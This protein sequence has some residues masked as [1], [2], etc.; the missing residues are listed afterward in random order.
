MIGV[1]VHD[2]THRTAVANL[3]MDEVRF[4]KPVFVGD[5]LRIETEVDGAAP[6][7]LPA[8]RRHRHVH[9]PRLQ[10]ARRG[11]GQLQASRAAAEAGHASAGMI[12]R[13]WLFVPGDSE[14]K[15]ARALDAGADAVI[16]DLEDAVV[17]ERKPL[18]RQMTAAFLAAHAGSSGPPLWVRVNPLVLRADARRPGRRDARRARRHHAAEAGF[19]CRRPGTRP[20]ARRAGGRARPGGPRRP[21]WR[22][23]PKRRWPWPR[24]PGYVRPPERLLALTWGAE[25]LAADLGAVANRETD[26]EFRFT[27]QLVRSLC[28]IAAAAVGPACHR[29]AVA[30]IS[31]TRRLWR[32]APRAPPRTASAACWPSTR[33]RC[34]S[35]MRPSRPTRGAGRAARAACWPPSPRPPTPA[36][37]Q[38]DGRMLDRPHRLQAERLLERAR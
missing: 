24:C 31:G 14:R 6:E 37:S 8:Q 26:G 15:L 18:A 20:G 25:D 17:A 9:P 16:L 11:S 2:T 27:Y 22:S 7:R 30:W 29:N 36:P 23:R 28:Q 35:S 3:G 13:S 5:T 32:G 38:L 10:S 34:R 12:P 1:S 19:D 21:S 33:P 4:P